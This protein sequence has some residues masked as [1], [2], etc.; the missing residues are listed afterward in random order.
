MNEILVE[1]GTLRVR[2]ENYKIPE[3]YGISVQIGGLKK[4]TSLFYRYFVQST[5]QPAQL[6]L[7]PRDRTVCVTINSVTRGDSPD[8]RQNR[9]IPVPI[10]AYVVAQA[11]INFL[12]SPEVLKLIKNIFDGHSIGDENEGWLTEKAFDS[13]LELE[14]LVEDI[15]RVEVYDCGEWLDHT[16]NFFDKDGDPCDDN[17]AVKIEIE[18]LGTITADSDPHELTAKL[19]NSLDANLRLY[20]VREYFGALIDELKQNNKG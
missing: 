6:E 14:D 4:R 1:H 15:D 12:E 17:E 16:L 9:I 8:I 2:G 18:G 20:H 3:D 10:S 11:L 19:E 7:D 5:P 13:L